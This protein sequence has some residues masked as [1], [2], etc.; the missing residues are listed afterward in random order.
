[1]YSDNEDGSSG[2]VENKSSRTTVN[3]KSIFKVPAR[4]DV[5]NRYKELKASRIL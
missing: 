2:I 4:I 1:M 3:L 5:K